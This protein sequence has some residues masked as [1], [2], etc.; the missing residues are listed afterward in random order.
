[1]CVGFGFF[2][3]AR[4][5]AKIEEP[6]AWSCWIMALTPKNA[7]GWLGASEALG[8]KNPQASRGGNR[9]SREER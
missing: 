7:A 4:A 2:L 3:F 9:N 6:P 1:M 5:R 8:A